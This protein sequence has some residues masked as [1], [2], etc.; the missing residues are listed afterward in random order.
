MLSEEYIGRVLEVKRVSDRMMYMTLDI[1]GVMMTVISAYA[2]QVG[3]L[4]EEKDKFWRD[5]DDVVESIPKEERVVIGADFNRH[6][7]EGN[8]GNENIMGRYG[9]KAMRT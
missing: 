4:I 6:V 9:D 8:R 5:L 2:P 3:C 1:D 7:G